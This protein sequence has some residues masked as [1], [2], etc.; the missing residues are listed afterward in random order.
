MLE[1]GPFWNEDDATTPAVL[2]IYEASAAS[3][4]RGV[5]AD[6]N[7]R[8]L[9]EAC[10]VAW[11]VLGA[12]DRMILTWLAQYEPQ[13]CMVIAGIIRRA[14]RPPEGTVTEWGVRFDGPPSFGSVLTPYKNEACARKQAR[15]TPKTA[16][17]WSATVMSRPVGPWTEAPETTKEE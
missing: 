12:Y 9:E 17:G 13:T 6:R 1:H 14:A 16:S 11:V 8:L 3:N 10:K 7:Q 4:D 5:M 2:A 15:I